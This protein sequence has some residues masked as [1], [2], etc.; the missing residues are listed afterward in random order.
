VSSALLVD[1]EIVLGRNSKVWR[2]LSSDSRLRDKNFIAISHAEL[3]N[4]SFKNKDRVWVFSY[5]R[6]EQENEALLGAL[7][8]SSIAEIVYVSSSSVKVVSKTNCYEYPRVKLKAEKSALENPVA[9]VLTI[10]LVFNQVSELPAGENIATSIDDLAGFMAAP[11]WP[12]N[13]QRTKNLFKIVTT[14]FSS[15]F[16]KMAYRLYGKLIFITGSYP[17]VLRPID[18]LLR[19]LKMRWYGYVYLSNQLWISTTSS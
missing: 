7:K 14:D 9:K 13:S 4:F 11:F 6:D 8:K 15:N 12:D 16:E 1:R 3:A 2:E 17:C 19:G 18:L 5:S 10:G